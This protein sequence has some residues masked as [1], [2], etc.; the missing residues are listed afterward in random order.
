MNINKEFKSIAHTTNKIIKT[1]HN[2][3]YAQTTCYGNEMEYD[4]M[5]VPEQMAYHIGS[6]ENMIKI[7]LIRILLISWLIKTLLITTNKYCQIPTSSNAYTSQ[8]LSSKNPYIDSNIKLQKSLTY[9]YY[10]QS[11]M[12]EQDFDIAYLRSKR[13]VIFSKII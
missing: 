12:K 4:T 1:K 2:A 3:K 6:M 7:K 13:K 11:A 5:K 10:S 9:I 8:L